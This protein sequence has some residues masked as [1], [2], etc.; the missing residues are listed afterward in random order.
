[1]SFVSGCTL[2]EEQKPQGGLCLP[3]GSASSS[4]ASSSTSVAPLGVR[5]DFALDLLDDLGVA[6]FLLETPPAIDFRK[7]KSRMLTKESTSTLRFAG[8]L[9]LPAL[10]IPGLMFKER[11]LNLPDLDRRPGPD[12]ISSC[13]VCWF[14][15]HQITRHVVWCRLGLSVGARNGAFP[16]ARPHRLPRHHV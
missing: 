15:G 1:M 13:P 16:D 11:L 2:Q 14:A 7:A 5:L 12:L 8:H 4:E 6:G 3:R 9:L 10:P